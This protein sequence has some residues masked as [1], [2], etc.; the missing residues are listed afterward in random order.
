MHPGDFLNLADP[1]VSDGFICARQ[2]AR[3]AERA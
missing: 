3:L 1:V 2:L